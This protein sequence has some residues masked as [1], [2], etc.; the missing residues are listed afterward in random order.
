MGRKE[1]REGEKRL[2]R[3]RKHYDQLTLVN[4]LNRSNKD[5]RRDNCKVDKQGKSGD[6][7]INGHL[8]EHR[9]HVN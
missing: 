6:Q 2:T 9:N 8:G 4:L 7:I 5:D 1:W 3:S